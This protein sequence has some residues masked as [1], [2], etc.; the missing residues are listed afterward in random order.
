MFPQKASLKSA[1]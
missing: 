1:L